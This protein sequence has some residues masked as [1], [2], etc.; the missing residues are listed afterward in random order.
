VL[1]CVHPAAVNGRIAPCQRVVDLIHGALAQAVP[2][3]V[4]AACNGVCASA[5]FIGEMPDTGKLW[6]YLETI[7]GGSGA[8]ADKD[9]LDGVHVHMTNT[10]NLPVEA[11]EVEYPLTILR[12]ELVDGS[13]GRGR[14]RG[15]MGLRRVYRAEAPCRLRVDNSR[16]LSRP[17]GINGGGEA[18]A[19]PAVRLQ[20][21][22]RAVRPRR[23]G[24]LARADR[25]DRHARRRRLRSASKSAAPAIARDARE[26]RYASIM[27]AA[28][29]RGRRRRGAVSWLARRSP[30]PCCSSGRWRRSSSGH[31]HHPRR[32]GRDAAV[33]AGR[34]DRP[35]GAREPAAQARAR[36]AAAGRNT[37]KAMGGCCRAISAPR[38]A[39]ARRSPQQIA[40]RLPRTLELIGAAGLI[41]VL[42]G[43]PLG[44]AAAVNAGAGSTGSSRRSRGFALAV[45]VFVVGT[46]L[47]MLF[48][49]ISALGAGRGLRPFSREPRCSI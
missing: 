48:A 28:R 41:A 45:P 25:R 22:R 14:H 5:T 2:E 47:I 26:R 13:G 32:S 38:C 43:V 30:L 24:A 49:Q 44:I 21:R 8:R 34:R 18:R 46:L 42:I 11:L 40:I 29:D 9:G 35:V 17:W 16:L 6:V 37:F 23:S 36:P 15:G 31:P 7:G 12:Y 3:R 1:N 27:N 20:R 4:I 19:R 10:S 39:T 33:A